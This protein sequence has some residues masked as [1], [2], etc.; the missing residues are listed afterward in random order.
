MTSS[1]TEISYPSSWGAAHLRVGT[2]PACPRKT[3]CGTSFCF[4]RSA[5]KASRGQSHSLRAWI[6]ITFLN[7]CCGF[8]S[9]VMSFGCAWLNGYSVYRKVVSAFQ[10]GR[11]ILCSLPFSQGI[12]IVAQSSS[13]SVKRWQSTSYSFGIIE[14]RIITFPTEGFQLLN[15]R[16]HFSHGLR[17][18]ILWIYCQWV[19]NYY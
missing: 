10:R 12:I 14:I 15:P 2:T 5:T 9:V 19:A 8:I 1:S 6:C 13:I 4:S 3:H 11:N 7:A 18:I 16:Q 17:N